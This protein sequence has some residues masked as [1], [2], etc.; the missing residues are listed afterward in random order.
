M[1]KGIFLLPSQNWCVHRHW[2]R[3]IS[4]KL[5]PRV[6]SRGETKHT[7]ERGLFYD[8]WSQLN[9]KKTLVIPKWLFAGENLVGGLITSFLP[10]SGIKLAMIG[11]SPRIFVLFLPSNAALVQWKQHVRFLNYIKLFSFLRKVVDV[12]Y[13]WL[14]ISLIGA[15]RHQ[16]VIEDAKANIQHH[17]QQQQTQKTFSYWCRL[18]S[19]IR[20]MACICTQMIHQSC[21]HRETLKYQKTFQI[22]WKEKRWI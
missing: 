7:S 10:R 18:E 15:L 22:S 9:C 12:R 8:W 3:W 6:T 2:I 5:L 14:I 17:Q 16:D 19:G 4:K 21:G 1:F 11:W 20:E 13:H